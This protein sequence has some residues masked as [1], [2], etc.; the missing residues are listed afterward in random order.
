LL[1]AFPASSGSA[2]WLLLLPF[3]R[4]LYLICRICRICHLLGEALPPWPHWLHLPVGTS[5]GA[6]NKKILDV[7]SQL[8][9]VKWPRFLAPVFTGFAGFTGFCATSL[10]SFWFCFLLSLLVLVL[11]SGF[12][13]CRLSAAFA[14]FD[15]FWVWCC[16]IGRLA[17]NA[18][19]SF[20]VQRAED[21]HVVAGGMA[22]SQSGERRPQP[23][24]T[25]AAHDIA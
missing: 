22:S 8:S 2:V 20:C 21:M 1:F 14:S 4:R 18:S 9:H 7:S 15:A 19:H 24:P 13:F 16:C 3:E 17:G 11:L 12:C 23:G 10:I 6:G 25:Q 5:R